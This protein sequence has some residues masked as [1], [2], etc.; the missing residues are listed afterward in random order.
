MK[1][2]H[3]DSN[4]N[5]QHGI[6]RKINGKWWFKPDMGFINEVF[7]KPASWQEVNINEIIVF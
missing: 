2:V 4:G 5:T 1:A 3:I 7:G 6:V